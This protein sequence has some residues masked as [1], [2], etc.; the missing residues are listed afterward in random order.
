MSSRGANRT[1]VSPTFV[2]GGERPAG[3]WNVVVPV[4]G[5]A[6]TK[7]RLVSTFGDYT[8]EMALAF[9]RDTL[10]AALRCS[11]VS[12]ITVVTRD[13]SL[14]GMLSDLAVAVMQESTGA[15]LNQAIRLAVSTQSPLG[16]VAVLLADLPSLRAAELEQALDAAARHDSAFLPD[17][18]GGG[19]T[20][21]TGR[22]PD[23]LH[24]RFGRESAAAHAALG[25]VRLDGTGLATVRCDVDDLADLRRA[26][27]LG[28][29]PY[30]RHA[31]HDDQTFR[32]A[33]TGMGSRF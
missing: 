24:A 16:R 4:K 30:T 10:C 12:S 20:L 5:T 19:T 25:A 29:G 3:G 11:A 15:D 27:E 1:L 33:V 9:A 7:S 32:R 14:A 13:E 17:I 2:E 6:Q 31:L 18:H 26:A 21:L 8:Y 28:L 23:L 22:R